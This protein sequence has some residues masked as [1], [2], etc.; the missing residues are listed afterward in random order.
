MSATSASPASDQLRAVSALAVIK[1]NWDDNKDYIANFVPVVAHCIRRA[2]HDTVSLPDTQ[3]LVEDTF[4]LRIPQGALRTILGRMARDGLVSRRHGAYARVPEALEEIDLGAARE[5]VLRQHAHLVALLVDFASRHGRE[6]DEAQAEQALLGYVEVL[7]EPILGAVVDGEPVV[8][9]PKIDSEGSVLTSRFVLD[10]CQK[11][12]QAFEYLVT[13]VKGTMLANVLFLPEAFS[14]GRTRLE[15]V[16]VFLDTPVVL[17]GLGYAEEP[18]RVPAEELIELLAQEGAKLRIFEHTLHEVEGVLDGAAATYRTGVQ[19]DHIPGDVVDFF[20][21]ENLGRSDVEMVIASLPER[22]KKHDI[23][24]VGPPDFSEDENL[25]ERDLETALKDGVHYGRHGTMVKDLNSLTAIYRLRKG[26][27]RR[28]VESCDAVMVTSN[29]TLAHVSRVYF[30]EMLGKR[31]VPLCM[32][33]YALAALAWLMN[34]TQAPD[35]PRRQIV[36]ISYAALNPPEEVWRKYLTE[37]R[38]L[39]ERGELTEEQVGLLLY[40]P[41]ARL[42]LMNATSGDADQMAGGTVAQ[43][44]RHAEKAARVEVERELKH[45]RSRREQTEAVAAAEKEHAA[46]EVAEA[47]RLADAH[48]ARLDTRAREVATFL[49]WAAFFVSAMI[50]VIGCVAAA[51]GLF[52]SSWS[53]VVP[54]GSALAFVL[55]LS[56]LV[57][58]LTGWNLLASRRSLAAHLEPWTSRLLHRWFGP[59]ESR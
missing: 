21:T 20:T 17:R 42:E 9:L 15:D 7:A 16:E 58:L 49:S 44:L 39:Q 3:T 19:R 24:V 56:S 6:W 38:R 25:S 47:R 18:Y 34:P 54:F 8:D 55:A 28:H 14:G 27:V 40:S 30:A 51:E 45:E 5:N 13:I 41:D 36:A 43:V 35:L 2:E 11:E 48:S 22:L 33:D 1:V 23:E 31:S 12:P 4:G 59:A 29:T 32:T 10:L 57:S 37:I 50:L 53:R 26:E 46:A 52:P